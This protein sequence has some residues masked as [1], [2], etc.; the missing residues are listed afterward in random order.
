MLLSR[1]PAYLKSVCGA[2]SAPSQSEIDCILGVK[3]K[4]D[5]M[6]DQIKSRY[7]MDDWF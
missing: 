2:L 1:H 5:A 6:L 7:E 3:D 4:A